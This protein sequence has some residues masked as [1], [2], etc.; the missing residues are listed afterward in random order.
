MAFNTI[1]SLMRLDSTYEYEKF[2]ILFNEGLDLIPSKLDEKNLEVFK[3]P[4][5][6][7]FETLIFHDYI[8]KEI[9]NSN[10]KNIVKISF[11]ENLHYCLIR[12]MEKTNQI[13]DDKKNM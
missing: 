4:L 3:T 11:W 9:A 5:R 12:I 7:I 10:E 6:E 8:F 2:I 13:A 1:C